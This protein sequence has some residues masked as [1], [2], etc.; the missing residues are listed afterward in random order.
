MTDFHRELREALDTLANSQARERIAISACVLNREENLRNGLD[1]RTWISEELIDTLIP[2]TDLPELDS[3]GLAWEGESAVGYF[4]DLVEGANCQLALNVMPRHMQPEAFRRKAA[5]L[6]SQGVENLFF[7]DSAGPSG[8]A[9][10][11]P[12]WNALRRLGHREEIEAWLRQGK[13]SLAPAVMPLRT[14]GDY[15]LTYQTPG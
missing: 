9:N 3:M 2:Y 5:A 4:V 14:V 15:D 13:P 8:R 7:W 1:V 10:F 12:G 6:Y 11:N